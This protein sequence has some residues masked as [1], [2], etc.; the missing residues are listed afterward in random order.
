MAGNS[1]DDRELVIPAVVRLSLGIPAWYE[2]VL[3][4]YRYFPVDAPKPQALVKRSLYSQLPEPAENLF[5]LTVT[6]IYQV[7]RLGKRP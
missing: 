1:N 3:S 7:M 6:T 2:P 5:Q 4:V